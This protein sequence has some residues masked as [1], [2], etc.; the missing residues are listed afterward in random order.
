VA[1]ARS[2]AAPNLTRRRFLQAGLAGAAG[3]ALYSGEVARHLIEIT[4]QEMRLPNL[5]L[6]FDGLHIAQLSDIHLDEFTEPFFLRMAIDH[7]NRLQPD[8][9]FLTGDFVTHELLPLKYPIRSAWKCAGLLNHIACTQRYAVL[10]NHDLAVNPHIVTEALSSI[11]VQ[12]L[13]NTF[14]PLERGPARIWLAGLDDAV[15]GV[16][17]MDRAMPDFMRNRPNEPIILLSHEPDVVDIVLKHPAGRSVQLM[18]SGHTHGGQ[19]RFPFIGPMNLPEWGK[20]YVEGSFRLQHLQLYVN[21]GIGT[22]GVPF[23]L[24]CP[25]EITL[26]TLRRA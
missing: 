15:E 25:P 11:G 7:I 23:R 21:R 12:V 8:M 16:P 18:L 24:N 9:V 10:G 20:K 14:A 17:D 13:R 26:F 19:V 3:I 6:A 4:Q 22:V 5:P 1:L 2:N